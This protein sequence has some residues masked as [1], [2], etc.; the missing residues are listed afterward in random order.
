MDHQKELVQQGILD[1]VLVRGKAG[2]FALI[3]GVTSCLTYFTLSLPFFGI[4]F[5][6]GCFL[7]IEPHLYLFNKRAFYRSLPAKDRRYYLSGFGYVITNGNLKYYFAVGIGLI[8]V[9]QMTR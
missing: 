7:A 5:V 1:G 2:V 9:L 6:M 3:F 8:A 4:A